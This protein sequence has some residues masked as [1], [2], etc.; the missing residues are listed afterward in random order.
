LSRE[1]N[2]KGME[3]DKYDP[4]MTLTVGVKDTVR[5][6]AAPLTFEELVHEQEV[7]EDAEY[8]T[9]VNDDAI[10]VAPDMRANVMD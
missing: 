3:I 8:D 9:V 5:E 10:V 2:Q 1:P 4:V 6:E 7:R